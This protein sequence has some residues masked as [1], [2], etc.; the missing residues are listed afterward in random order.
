MPVIV[1]I[2][3][4][5]S[6]EKRLNPKW[7]YIHTVCGGNAT[8]C[9]GEFFGMGESGCKFE[10]KKTERGGITCDECLQIIKTIK[11]IKL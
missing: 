11:S 4:D 5:H 3:S 10:I 8:L 7:H 6:G 2:I 1:K 9:E